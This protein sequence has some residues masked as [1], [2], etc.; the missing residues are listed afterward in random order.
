VTAACDTF[1]IGFGLVLDDRDDNPELTAA[2]QY[3]EHG[4]TVFPVGPNKRPLTEHGFKDATTD[5]VVITKWWGRSPNAYIGIPVPEGYVVIDVD[6]QRGGL[7]TELAFMMGGILEPTV[8]FMSGGGGRHYW[9][10]LPEGADRDRLRVNKIPNYPGVD[11]KV[12]GKGYV[13][14]PPSGHASG[15]WYWMLSEP[16]TQVQPINDVLLMLITHRKPKPRPAV[17]VAE[18]ASRGENQAWVD[19]AIRGTL[20]DFAAAVEGDR[21]FALVRTTNRLMEFVKAGYV[22]EDWVRD[23]VT[24]IGLG[25]ERTP[26]EIGA[27]FTWAHNK[28]DP[29]EVPPPTPKTKAP[30]AYVLNEQ[31]PHREQLDQQPLPQEGA[32]PPEK[33]E[34]DRHVNQARFAYRLAER[35]KDKLLHVYGIGW[36]YWTGKRWAL[37]NRGRVSQAVLETLRYELNLAFDAP[38]ADKKKTL[39]ADVIRCQTNNAVRGIRD[40]A[41]ALAEFAATVDDLDTDPYV[42]NVANGTLNLRTLELRPHSPG[43]RITK[44]CRG[45]Y[46][47]DAPAPTWQAVLDRVLPKEDVREFLQRLVGMSLIGEV[48]EHKLPILTG[49][50]RNGKGTTYKAALHALGD[51]AGTADPELF[52]AREGAHP[53]G[54]MDLRGRRLVVV[55][56]S[57]KDRRLDEARMKRLCGGDPIKARYMRKDF[58]EFQPSHQAYL[59]TNHLPKVSPDDPA[60]WARLRVVPF[61]VSI[62]EHEQDTG[63][64]AKLAAEADGILAWAVAGLRDYLDHGLDE[65]SAVLKATGAYKRDMDALSRFIDECCDTGPNFG[66][67]TKELHDAWKIW[68]QSEGCEAIGLLTFGKALEDRGYRSTRTRKGSWRSGICVRDETVLVTENSPQLRKVTSVTSSQVP[69]SRAHI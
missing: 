68:Q 54:E 25:L 21:H 15:G 23:Q 17:G 41:A 63:L 52:M 27:A 45:A 61:D 13:I 14:A 28:V 10:R 2:L 40:L 46:H 18:P 9:Y 64:D 62:P 65:P 42:L 47:P 8:R 19:A 60:T 31:P 30:P 59:V 66:A 58:V 50:G 22:A 34:L 3:A 38:D 4:I 1:D 16:G 43:D 51:Y 33:T 5:P 35:Y 55:S 44:V 36:H 12:G 39:L 53:T 56:E 48:R 11:I 29:A 20:T 7:E 37:D 67:T 32:P 6:V 26:I 49:T 69:P 57:S 24:E